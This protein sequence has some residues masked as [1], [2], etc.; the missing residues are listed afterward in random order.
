MIAP[1]HSGVVPRL[2]RSAYAR[3]LTHSFRC[4]LT[5][6]RRPYGA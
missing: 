5:F 4:G 3:L 6:G 2:W 1:K